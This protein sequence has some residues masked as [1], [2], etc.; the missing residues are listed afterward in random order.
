M[1]D[2]KPELTWDRVCQQVGKKRFDSTPRTRF[3]RL[4]QSSKPERTQKRGVSE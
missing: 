1:I 4:L 2:D 3:G